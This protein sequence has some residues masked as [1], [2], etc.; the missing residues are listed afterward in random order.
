MH[1]G[2]GQDKMYRY[3]METNK[4]VEWECCALNKDVL[5]MQ[6]NE[7]DIFESY[8]K[9]KGL[10]MD[11]PSTP[12]VVS[13]RVDQNEIDECFQHT[14]YL[15]EEHQRLLHDLELKSMKIH[16]LEEQVSHMKSIKE[17]TNLLRK[18]TVKVQH[19]LESLDRKRPFQPGKTLE[20]LSSGN[21]QFCLGEDQTIKLGRFSESTKG[22]CRTRGVV[23]DSKLAIIDLKQY[24]I[25][26]VNA[27][28]AFQGPLRGG[29]KGTTIP[30][31]RLPAHHSKRSPVP[32]APR[33]CWWSSRGRMLEQSKGQLPR[34]FS[35]SECRAKLRSGKKM[36]FTERASCAP[37]DIKRKKTTKKL[38]GGAD[39]KGEYRWMTYSSAASYEGEAERLGV[40]EVARSRRGFM[41]QYQKAGSAEAMRRRPV[42]GSRSGQT[43]GRRRANFIKRHMAQYRRHRTYRRWLALA[44]WAYLPPGPPPPKT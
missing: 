3:D 19:Q 1:A 6:E 16:D 40:S 29:G 25:P 17:K 28:F 44:M 11:H 22:Q 9:E 30:C 37:Y 18:L 31:S 7:C 12:D 39:P 21:L 8:M 24:G 14:E 15:L 20:D 35:P 27:K 33:R 5:C 26:H 4:C 34:L 42:A 10:K 41:R 23:K 43:W 38:R 32:A 13:D 36:G 2:G